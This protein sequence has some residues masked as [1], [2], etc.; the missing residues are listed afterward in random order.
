MTKSAYEVEYDIDMIE[1]K[2]RNEFDLDDNWYGDCYGS[3]LE[4]E[5]GS[6][7]NMLMERSKT[8]EEYQE[9]LDQIEENFRNAAKSE[10]LNEVNNQ[11]ENFQNEY[12]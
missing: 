6:R 9:L 4:N 12:L 11:I 8:E 3:L 1:Q 7:L 2:V 10:Y 5:T